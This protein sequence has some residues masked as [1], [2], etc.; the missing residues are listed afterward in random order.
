MVDK[1]KMI[2]MLCID[3]AFGIYTRNYIDFIIDTKYKDKEFTAVIVDFN[4]VKALNEV[5]GYH[6][7]NALFRET[8][9]TFK[10]SGEVLVG[11]WFSGDEI[12]LITDKSTELLIIELSEHC[13]K[14]NLSFKVIVATT[15]RIDIEVFS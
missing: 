14:Y 3:R 2:R 6:Y 1:D 8:F 7:V 9:K 12:I 10:P 5:F 4:G 13:A 15:K 11:R